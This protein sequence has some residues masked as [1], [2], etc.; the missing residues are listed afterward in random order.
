MKLNDQLETPPAFITGKEILHRQSA[1]QKIS[2]CYDK[3][4]H[5]CINLVS[6]S[7]YHWY[8]WTHRMMYT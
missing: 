1:S 3:M 7:V 5:I 4:T 6:C 8:E 2:V